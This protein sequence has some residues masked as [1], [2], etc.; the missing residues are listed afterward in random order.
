MSADEA[1]AAITGLFASEGAAEYLGE[2]VS[3][4]VITVPA[5]FNDSQ[6]QAT[7]D[8]GRI[9]GLSA[10]TARCRQATLRLAQPVGALT[11]DAGLAEEEIGDDADDR[12][13]HDRRDPG[14]PRGRRPVRPSDRA[15]PGQ[16]VDEEPA[17]R[18]GHRDQVIRR[19]AHDGSISLTTPA[20]V[21][22]MGR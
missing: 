2:P 13:A 21:R 3:Q 14:D 4:A 19:P 7:K 17:G 10:R 6:R 1:V 9:A 5:Y 18:D 22:R 8:A 16:Q 15:Q 11:A 20:S 12:Q